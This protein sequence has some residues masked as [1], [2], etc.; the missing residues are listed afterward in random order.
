MTWSGGA[1]GSAGGAERDEQRR[2]VLDG[3]VG[4]RHPGRARRGS[5][6][7]RRRRRAAGPPPPTRRTRPTSRAQPHPATSPRRNGRPWVR[8]PDPMMST[9]SSRSGRSR[10]PR[11]MQPLRVLGGQAHLQH[12]DVAERVHHRQ[13]TQAPWSR[14]RLPCWCTGSVS[15]IRDVTRRARS[16]APEWRTSSDRSARGS[17]RSRRPAGRPARWRT[18]QG[19]VSQCAET[20]RIAVGRGRSWPSWV[21]CEVHSTSSSRGGAP[22][23]M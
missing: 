13:G 22:C 8:N 14:P 3:R 16:F 23:P 10:R 18:G 7:A 9:P 21:S 11:S 2:E 1:S 15:G 5:R 20:M 12:R 4:V 17:R 19:A 6:R